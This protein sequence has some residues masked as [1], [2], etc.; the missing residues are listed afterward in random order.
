MMSG[1][2]AGGDPRGGNT[3]YAHEWALSQVGT[4]SGMTLGVDRM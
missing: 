3:I 4:R 1:Y 2:G